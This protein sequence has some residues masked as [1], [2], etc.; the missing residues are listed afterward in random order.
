MQKCAKTSQT[1]NKIKVN[2]II[3]VQ[4]IKVYLFGFRFSERG[5]LQVEGS[6][7]NEMSVE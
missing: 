5:E 7:R 1:S 4:E 2:G 6:R 3:I